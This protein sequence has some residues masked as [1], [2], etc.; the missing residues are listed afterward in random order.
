VV[1]ATEWKILEQ[2]AATQVFVATSP[3]V[4]GVSGR[5]FADSNESELSDT[6]SGGVTPHAH[7]EDAA[8]RLWN[9]SVEWLDW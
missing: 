7:D 1:D 4:D 2:G 5:Y 3:L 6:F 9:L 8:T